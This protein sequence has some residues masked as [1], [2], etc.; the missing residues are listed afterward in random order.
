M[1]TWIKILDHAGHQILLLGLA[2]GVRVLSETLHVSSELVVG[3]IF[4][5]LTRQREKLSHSNCSNVRYFLNLTSE[6]DPCPHIVIAGNSIS[7]MG[8]AVVLT[9]VR[10]WLSCQ[11]F[12]AFFGEVRE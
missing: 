1:F 10:T 12:Q 2:Q 11:S 6:M 7:E 4:G 5:D 9:E 3:H 8:N